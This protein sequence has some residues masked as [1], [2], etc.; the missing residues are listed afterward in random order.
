MCYILPSYDTAAG[1][2]FFHLYELLE[3]AARDLDIL[4]IIEKAQVPP[5]GLPLRV[6]CQKFSFLPLRLAEL[7]FIAGLSR[8]SGT[9]FF[10]THYS[11]FGALASWLVVRIF[12]GTAYYWNCGMPWLY[13]RGFFEET[14]FRFILRHLILVTGTAGLAAEYLKHYALRADRMRI[15]PNWITTERFENMAERKIMRQTLGIADSRMVL[16]VHRLSRRKGAHYIPP[17]ARAVTEKLRNVIFLIVGIGP[18]SENLKSEIRNGGLE[19]S[20]RFAGEIPHR[21]IPAY[22]AAADVLFMPSEEEGFPHVLLEAM[23]SGVPYTAGD[24]GGVRDITP[25][26]L[27]EYIVPSGDVEAY[28]KNIINLLTMSDD[29]RRR[30]FEAERIWVKQYDVSAA[31][32]KFIALF[33]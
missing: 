14:V 10:Y 30:L 18:E 5:S 20:V 23:A 3:R 16:F 29:A 1:S 31:E 28:T 27:Q 33:S 8:L 6:Y 9:R 21:D 13:Q 22:F 15:M 7:I 32:P 12:G 11:F 17:V 2:H 4:L 24:V 19:G 25:P 26:E